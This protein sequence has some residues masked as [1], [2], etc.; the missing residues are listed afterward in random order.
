MDQKKL[1]E[2]LHKEIGIVGKALKWFES[3]LMGRYQNVKIGD[4]YSELVEL[5]FGVAQESVLGP[6]LFSIYIRSLYPYIQPAKFDIFGFADDH[7]LLTLFRP[8]GCFWSNPLSKYWNNFLL[9]GAIRMKS[10]DFS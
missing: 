9:T 8:G 1:L 10:F 4:A 5:L 2:I 3:F 6:D 7:Q